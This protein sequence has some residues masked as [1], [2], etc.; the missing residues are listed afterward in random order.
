MIPLFLSPK[1]HS[2]QKQSHFVWNINQKCFTFALQTHRKCL[3]RGIFKQQVSSLG[4]KNPCQ[5]KVSARPLT[6]LLFR[7]SVSLQRS[8][9]AILCLQ[10]FNL[11][12]QKVQ[13]IRKLGEF[14]FGSSVHEIDVGCLCFQYPL[15]VQYYLKKNG[16]DSLVSES[17]FVL[18][19]RWDYFHTSDGVASLLALHIQNTEKVLDFESY[20]R[21]GSNPHFRIWDYLLLE[22]LSFE[23]IHKKIVLG[24]N[25]NFYKMALALKGETVWALSDFVAG[26]LAKY[27]IFSA[28]D[29]SPIRVLGGASCYRHCFYPLDLVMDWMMRSSMLRETELEQIKTYLIYS[30]ETGLYK[31][32]KTKNLARRISQLG[33]RLEFVAWANEDK[34]RF[35]HR[36]FKEQRVF[37][38]WFRFS[39][40]QLV[41]VLN[42]FSR[43]GGAL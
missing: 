38:E 10:P 41:E 31:I 33:E 8:G 23:E 27:E 24:V 12:M 40:I 5:T 9:R 19:G 2:P 42:C 34:E 6:S 21:K 39:D 17:D 15:I 20:I 30:K 14:P 22:T 11:Q 26:S 3:L 18:K 32:G 1:K 13:V 28:I 37:Q 36:K 16:P 29:G 43:E 7:S 35:L 25:A 4:L